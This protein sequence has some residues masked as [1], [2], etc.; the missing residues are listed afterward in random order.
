MMMFLMWLYL[1][2]LISFYL[3][4]INKYSSEA[5]EDYT[6]CGY[7][8]NLTSCTM[9][10]HDFWPDYHPPSTAIGK[11]SQVQLG[12]FNPAWI[13]AIMQC[14]WGV[15]MVSE[16]SG[17]C[18][19]SVWKVSGRSLEGVCYVPRSLLDVVWK[20]FWRCLESVWKVS[21]M[22][23]ESVWKVSGMCLECIWRTSGRCLKA[24]W[25]PLES[26]KS[27]Q[28]NSGQ[29]K[30]GQVKSGKVKSGQVRSE[31]GQ[32]V[33][34]ILFE[35]FLEVVWNVSGRLREGIWKASIQDRSSGAGQVGTGQVRTGQVQTGR[36]G[37]GQA[38][39]GQVRTGQALSWMN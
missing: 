31:I 11:K 21:G 12:N 26:I 29:V 23:L 14:V 3:F 13:F 2:F 6:L 4:V 15:W 28:V 22:C 10:W 20:V 33:F 16:V 32:A 7:N 5:H 18:F 38:R 24:S 9:K 27:E 17:I 36:L 35:V 30:S 19:E 34:W 1:L 39:T 37:T 25:R 8:C